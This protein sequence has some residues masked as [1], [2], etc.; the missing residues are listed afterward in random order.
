MKKALCLALLFVMI[1]VIGA[2]AEDMKADM[3]GPKWFDMEDCEFC[4][5]LMDDP[6][7]MEHMTW[8][9]HDISNG[10]MSIATVEPEYRE[11]YMKAMGAMET[12]AKEMETGKRNP[13]EVKMC[14]QCQAYGMLVMGGA[15]AEYVQ[16]AAAD[17]SLIT[18]NDEAMVK[19]IHDYAERNR[20]ELAKWNE[21][22]KRKVVE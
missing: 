22:L 6:H 3:G 19:K 12:L 20:T 14:G 16:S 4:K 8:E 10:A 15:K 7:L 18:S 11:S 2:V 9:W 5:H 21:E 17:V 1:A 13:M